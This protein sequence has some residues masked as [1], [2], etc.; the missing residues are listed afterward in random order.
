MK[1]LIRTVFVAFLAGIGGSYTYDYLTEEQDVSLA[2]TY[3]VAHSETD[4]P[5]YQASQYCPA[6]ISPELRNVPDDFVEASR[7]STPSVV[8]IKTITQNDYGRNS[9]LEY[10][11]GGG[12]GSQ[13]NSGSGVIYTSDGY[14]ITNN[15]VV[16]GADQL[17]VIHDKKTYEARIVGRDP[18]S[19]LAVIKVEASGLP[20][21]KVGRSRDIQTGEWVLAVGNPFNL[22]STVTAGIVSAKGRQINILRNTSFPLESF[23]QTDAAINPGN[24]GGA[25]VNRTGEL[26]GINTAIISKTGSYAGYGFAVPSDVAKKIADDIINYGTVQKAFIGAEVV[27]VDEEI[28]RQL[29]VREPEGVVISYLEEGG[30]A[31]K[32]G[33]QRGDIILDLGGV[34]TG[35]HGNYSEALSYYSPGDK[36]PVTYKRKGKLSSTSLLLTNRD[37]STS[38]VRKEFYTSDKLGAELESLSNAEKRK[39]NIE[40]GVRI[41]QIRTGLI[42]QMG[43]EEGFVVTAVNRKPVDSPE[44]LES[45]LLG[46]RGRVIVE[47]V[48]TRGVRGYYSFVF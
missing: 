41:S 21:I 20:A 43:F 3:P 35:S 28:A 39:R 18:S 23:I 5:A 9:W 29:D 22:T 25:L 11:F 45:M 38:L 24:S 16:E 6:S 12:G 13:I 48:N 15:H 36:V 46:I 47:G 44:D 8:Y 19:D 37:G 34:K 42:R 30:A 33:L 31:E 7:N 10:F 40:N 27:G 14:I 1:Q 32:A 2:T 17:E 26:V 4:Q